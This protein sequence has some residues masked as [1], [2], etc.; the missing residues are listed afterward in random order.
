[1]ALFINQIVLLSVLLLSMLIQFQIIWPIESELLSYSPIE[2]A[3]LFFLP[4]GLKAICI[5][6]IGARAIVPIF[7]MHFITD[8]AIGWALNIA[9]LTGVVA[10][11]VMTLPLILINF[12]SHKPA[13]EPLTLGSTKDLSLFRLVVVVAII[14]SLLNGAIGAIRY[15]D[16]PLDLVAFRFFTGDIIGTI[17]VLGILLW[18]KRPLMSVAN[19]ISRIG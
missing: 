15:Q 11:F 17:A 4:H 8:L 7:M 19:R 10:V 9:L 14:A 5:V 13:L 3:S 16:S 6:L 12:L 2:V 1:M 18:L